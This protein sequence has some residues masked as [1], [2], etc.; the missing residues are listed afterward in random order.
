MTGDN[1]VVVGLKLYKAAPPFGFTSESGPHARLIQLLPSSTVAEGISE[2]T[3]PGS[4]FDSFV[5]GATPQPA[6]APASGGTREPLQ[7]SNV[8]D[9]EALLLCAPGY[10]VLPLSRNE[11]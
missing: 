4:A 11:Y 3:G 5:P 6:A 8:K 9:G 1:G 7:D 10:S 2:N